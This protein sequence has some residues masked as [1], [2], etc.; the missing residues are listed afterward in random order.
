M[1]VGLPLVVSDL[2]SLRELFTDGADARFFAADDAE[3]L[4]A[5]IGAVMGDEELRRGLGERL[6]ARAPEHTWDARA[7]RLLAWMDRRESAAEE[8]AA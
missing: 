6:L 5:A 3:A 7:A 1:A 8:R 2:P 4:A